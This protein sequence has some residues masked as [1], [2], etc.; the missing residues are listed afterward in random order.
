MGNAAST[1]VYAYR[2]SCLFSRDVKGILDSHYATNVI[3]FMAPAT[4]GC[5]CC[6]IL[7]VESSI[8]AKFSPK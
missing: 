1:A 4:A 2:G 7:N 8:M 5:D 3:G 6:L